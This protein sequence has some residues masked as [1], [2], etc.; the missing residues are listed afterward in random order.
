MTSKKI[1]L[2]F[3]GQGAQYAGM[4]KALYDAYPQ[5]KALFERADAELKMPLSKWILEGPEEELTKTSISQPAIYLVSL[6]VLTC[7]KSRFPQLTPFYAAG[8]SLGEYSALAAAGAFDPWEGLK[9]VAAR[10]RFMGEACESTPGAMAA[11]LG[12]SQQEVESFVK[13]ADLPNDLWAANFNAPGQTVISGT[14]AGVE[15]GTALAKEKGAKKVIPLKVHGAFHS[16]LMRQAQPRLKEKI[17]AVSFHSPEIRVV[18]NASADIAKNESE[19]KSL[20]VDQIILPVRWQ[21]SIERLDRDGVDLY[22]ELGCGK[23]LAALN[24]RIGVKGMTVSIETPEDLD[25]LEKEL[26]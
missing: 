23:T 19:F 5:V 16:G 12:L 21:E 4:G 22:L 9:L 18:M 1:A 7:L 20:L 2:L 13:E 6:A 3:P 24:K 8:L 17:D 25:L 11:L 14:L 26:I 10:G 15:K